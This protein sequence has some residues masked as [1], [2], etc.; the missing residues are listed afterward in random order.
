MKLVVF[1]Q[2]F[3]PENFR[4]NDLV[5]AILA[6][7]VQVD[8]VT[9][10]PNYPQGQTYDGYRS[11]KI[12]RQNFGGATVHR[13]PIVP[14]GSGS[15][16][17]L[18]LNYLSFVMSGI[19]FAPMVLRRKRVDVVLVYAI[20]PI[21]QAIPAIVLKWIKGAKLVIWVQ[22]LWP[23]SLEATGFVRNRWILKAVRIVVRWIY[24]NADLILVQ[25]EAFVDPVAALA[26]REKICYYP[27]SADNIFSSSAAATENCPIAGLG[28]GFSV[29]FAGNLGAAQ[30]VETIINAAELLKDIPNIHIFLVGD[31]SRA[32]WI[33]NAIQMRGL[34]NVIMGGQHPIEAMPAILSR[35]DALLVTLKDEPIFYHTVPSK[36]QVYLA[37]GRPIIA[38]LNGEGARIVKQAD[39]GISCPA[40]NAVSLAEAILHLSSMSSAERSRLGENGQ[41]YFNTHY[42]GDTLVTELLS[43]FEN[44]LSKS[45]H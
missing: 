44:L 26:N 18:I 35:A 36:V 5:N 27:N 16:I 17:R 15:A 9:G 34:T 19:L 24:R 43:H 38:S 20:S 31:G 40:E 39:A 13:L 45:S 8:V 28:E 37:M 4:I 29:V 12:A 2:Y 32:N 23:E 7:N 3:W 41:Q 14:R 21:L 10:Q 11:W 22:D 1:S 6:K 42:D 33:R 30:A 25:S